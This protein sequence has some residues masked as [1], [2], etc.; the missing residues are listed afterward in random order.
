M[1]C[2]T[3]S[4]SFLLWSQTWCL[5]GLCHSS[6]LRWV[7]KPLQHPDPG[8]TGNQNHFIVSTERLP[9]YCKGKKANKGLTKDSTKKKI[10]RIT[11]KKVSHFS[12]TFP[13]NSRRDTRSTSNRTVTIKPTHFCLLLS[14]SFEILIDHALPTYLPF[15]PELHTV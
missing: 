12:I 7:W 10:E 4:Q 3:F 15:I 13:M 14:P 8:I 11:Y 2:S 6:K 5:C 1:L 9:G